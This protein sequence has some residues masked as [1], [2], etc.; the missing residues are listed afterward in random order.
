[1]AHI[2][3]THGDP[4]ISQ[5]VPPDIFPR[6]LDTS[7]PHNFSTQTIPPYFPSLPLAPPPLRNFLWDFSPT[8]SFQE[9]FHSDLCHGQL[10]FTVHG[11]GCFF[12]VYVES[13]LEAETEMTFHV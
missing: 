8:A 2:T 4:A 3:A 9:I 10:S 1:M 12:R 6:H 11:L 7:L 5:D 13:I